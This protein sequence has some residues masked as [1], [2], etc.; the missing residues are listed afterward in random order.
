MGQRA[1]GIGR[2]GR[3]AENSLKKTNIE[4]PTLNAEWEKKKKQTYHIEEQL[5]AYSMF[6][7]GRSSF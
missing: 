1:R 7:V 6:N 5:L 4:R 2:R 3:K